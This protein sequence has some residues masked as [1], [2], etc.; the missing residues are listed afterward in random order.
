MMTLTNEREAV[1]PL[2]AVIRSS[3]VRELTSFWM[4]ASQLHV[5][6]SETPGRLIHNSLS[7]KFAQFVVAQEQYERDGLDCTSQKAQQ[8]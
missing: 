7:D 6:V 3:K 2:S 4:S 1:T 8:L 5:V